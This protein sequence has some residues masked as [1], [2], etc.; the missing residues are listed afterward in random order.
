MGYHWNRLDE[1]VFM[2]CLL[3]TITQLRKL[4]LFKRDISPVT[5][6]NKNI[7]A[8]GVLSSHDSQGKIKKQ[9]SRN[10][11]QKSMKTKKNI[12]DASKTPRLTN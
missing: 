6:K 12:T 9:S 1:H 7:G 5:H 3:F 2:A 11:G 8:A 4:H 10:L